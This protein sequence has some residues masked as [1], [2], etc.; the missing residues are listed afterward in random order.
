MRTVATLLD[1]IVALMEGRAPPVK[2]VAPRSSSLLPSVAPALRVAQ[3]MPGPEPWQAQVI[4][5]IENCRT[6]ALGGHVAMTADT[7]GSPTTHAA[8]GIVP[9]ARAPRDAPGWRLARPAC[10]PSIRLVFALYAIQ[11]APAA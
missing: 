3:F 1:K 8:T 9:S 6:A 11:D 10:S 4:T 2:R 5:A 7:G